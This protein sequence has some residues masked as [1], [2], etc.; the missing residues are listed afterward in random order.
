M[1]RGRCQLCRD[2]KR[3]VFILSASKSSQQGGLGVKGQLARNTTERMHVD[4]DGVFSEAKELALHLVG[5]ER[6]CSG[7]LEHL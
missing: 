3:V 4:D 1:F 7:A 5:S 6:G 2:L